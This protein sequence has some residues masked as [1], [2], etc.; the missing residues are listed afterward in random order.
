M[1][2][3]FIDYKK[4]NSKKTAMI[5]ATSFVFALSLNTFLFGTNAGA[6]LQTSVLNAGS[7]TVASQKADIVVASAGT[8]TDMLKIKTTIVMD[9][10]SSMSISFAFDPEA[11][12]ISDVFSQNKNIVVGKIANIPGQIT[13]MLLLNKPETLSANSE[14]VTLVYKKKKPGITSINLAETQYFKSSGSTY[15][16]LSNS[17]FEF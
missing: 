13:L 1:A 10:V 2:D 14:I 17:P 9:T 15:T 4:K 8:G 6:R 11:L 3:L 12:I 7:T 5:V 16:P